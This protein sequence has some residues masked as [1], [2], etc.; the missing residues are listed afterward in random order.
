MHICT[1]F[2]TLRAGLCALPSICTG[3]AHH[4]NRII[5]AYYYFGPENF[6]RDP[7]KI[8]SKQNSERQR[9][10]EVTMACTEE[11]SA[12]GQVHWWKGCVYPLESIPGDSRSTVLI[13][14]HEAGETIHRR[15]SLQS[16]HRVSGH[17]RTNEKSHFSA[18]QS[19]TLTARFDWR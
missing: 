4:S 16:A 18:D 2:V 7:E 5:W 13:Q 10:G 14:G 8:T 11:A 19:E 17:A 15:T 12:C 1:I 6:N 9:P 3:Q